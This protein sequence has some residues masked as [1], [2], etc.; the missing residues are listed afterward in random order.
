MHLIPI[1]ASASLSL[2]LLLGTSCT[3]NKTPSLP[4][5]V[6]MTSV[7]NADARDYS[8]YT[9]MVWSDDFNGAGTPDASKWAYDTGGGGWGN[10]EFETYTTSTNNVFQNGGNLIIQ[11]VKEPSG[12]PAYTSGRILTKGKKDFMFGR[13]DVRAKLPQGVGVWPAIWMLGSDIDQNNWPKCGEIDIMELRGQN[14]TEILT[15]MHFADPAGNHQQ[16]GIPSVKLPDG[17]S[18][19]N[20][21][22]T[23]SVVRSKDQIRFYLDSKLYYTF[24]SSDTGSNPYPFNNNFFV[25]LN[26]AVGGNFLS[27]PSP[28][29]INSSTTFPQQMQVDYVRYYQYKQ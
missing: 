15:T 26:V 1:I 24:S 23:Y 4:P 22:H 13:I 10:Q 3:E 8:E 20:D 21:F 5:P 19:A 25:V 7:T 2:A 17:S 11:A 9:E 14:P 12:S 29:A 16:A 6:V 28:A 27:N 18:F